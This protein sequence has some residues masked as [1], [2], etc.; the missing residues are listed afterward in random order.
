MATDITFTHTAE[1][2][3]IIAE[4][5]KSTPPLRADG[6]SEEGEAEVVL[7]PVP[8]LAQVVA[9]Q[10]VAERIRAL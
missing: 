2:T 1:L 4:Q 8:A 10:A 9:E 7:A 5:Q 6:A 3:L